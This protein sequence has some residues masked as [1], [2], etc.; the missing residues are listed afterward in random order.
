MKTL[1]TTLLITLFSF[2]G[3]SQYTPNFLSE[4][5]N[6]YNGKNISNDVE[7]KTIATS[8]SNPMG[9]AQGFTFPP[10]IQDVV[11][12]CETDELSPKLDWY[13]VENTF[14]YE[15]TATNS[16]V[17]FNVVITS[18]CGNGNV[19]NF[20][21]ILYNYPSCTQKSSGNINNLTFTGLTVG[22]KYVF[23][24]KF[25]VP[26]IVVCDLYIPF[27]GCISSHY[28]YCEHTRHCPF[29]V[30]ATTP[31]PI[32][33]INFNVNSE[34]DIVHINWKTLTETNNDYFEVQ[35]SLDGKTWKTISKVKGAG[36]SNDIIDYEE[37]DRS[38]YPGISYYKLKQVDYDGKSE[39]F[40]PI[41]VEVDFDFYPN[42]FDT[43][44]KVPKKS[45]IVL[46]DIDGR[47]LNISKDFDIINTENLRNGIYF[48]T[49]NG[50]TN[51][52]IKL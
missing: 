9:D 3:Y 7:I 25:R 46:T 24:Y 29:F 32:E 33:L 41:S 16:T 40:G 44:I 34:N 12:G 43:Y 36:N 19:T 42:P 21:W 47:I 4:S 37:I 49:V 5:T 45:N 30:G 13:D 31:L 26:Q 27:L 20:S 8:C 10:S 14:C 23:C 22:N 52:I 11:D 15:F 51:T 28:E 50:I 48:L 18:D 1:I 39:E 17:N 2:I 35:R 6:D 38:P